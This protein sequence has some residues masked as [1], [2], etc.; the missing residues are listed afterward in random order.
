MPSGWL[1]A[2]GIGWSRMAPGGGVV[3]PV[4]EAACSVNQRK[5]SGP[6]TMPHG[7]LLA[8]GI[9]Y[10]ATAPPARTPIWL[11]PSSVNQRVPEAPAVISHGMLLGVS[12]TLNGWAS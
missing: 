10:S 12:A 2:L 4:L 6:S 3:A 5:P 11:A 8:V 1:F 7:L 9:G